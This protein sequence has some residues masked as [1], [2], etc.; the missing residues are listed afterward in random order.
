MSIIS[1]LLMATAIVFSFLTLLA[2][3]VWLR[4]DGD[5]V[6]LPGF[7]LVAS[8]PALIVSLLIF[9]VVFVITAAI[10][11]PRR[12]FVG[13]TTLKQNFNYPGGISTNKF[14]E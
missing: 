12:E 13:Q 5:A 9:D 1:S 2:L 14:D 8:T 10:T 7:G 4:A 11:K 3:L 6:L